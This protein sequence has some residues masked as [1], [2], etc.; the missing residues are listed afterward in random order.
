MSQNIV[1]LTG[2][3]RPHGNSDA[4]AEAFIRGAKAAGNNVI[5]ISAHQAKVSPCKDCKY[6]FKHPGECSQKDDMAEILEE[7]YK[8][9]VIV[10]ST[11][12]YFFGLT[13]QI[14]T[15][16]DRLYPSVVKPFPIKEAIFMSIMADT[17]M[18]TMV[19]SVANFK[20]FASYLGWDIKAILTA[21]GINDAGD[22]NHHQIL[23]DAEALGHS[24]S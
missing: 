14:K 22:I 20:A 3:P 2:S 7:L 16:I 17:N 10:F 9:D 15:I 18:E 12:V 4:L 8:A 1:V 6:C 5:K 24:L 13:A 19:P 11:P 23:E 21:G